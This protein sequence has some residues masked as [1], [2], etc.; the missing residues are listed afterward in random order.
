MSRLAAVAGLLALWAGGLAMAATRT[1]PPL[2]ATPQAFA[3]QLVAL[4]PEP[5]TTAR[6][7]NWWHWHEQLYDPEFTR[8]MDENE[9]F[10]PLVQGY[11]DLDHDPL[12]GCQ[13]SN[14][15]FRI[16]SV[17]ARKDGAAEIKAAHCYPAD[18]RTRE[19]EH[20][21]D[22]DLIVK[23]IGGAGRLYDVIERTSLR[24]RLARHNACLRKAKTTDAAQDCLGA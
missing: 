4:Y 18:A 10:G 5:D 15:F 13:T 6:D 9:S 17:M 20:C 1:P 2:P 23:R 11:A 14:G 19:P 24:E 16:A 22:V 8:L 3:D 12:C 7:P 21:T